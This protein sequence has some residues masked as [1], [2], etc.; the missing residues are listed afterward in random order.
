VTLI[1]PDGTES[2]LVNRPENGAFA[3]IYGF[4]GIDFLAESNAH[5]G[6]SSAGIWTLKIQ[7]AAGG[8]AGTLNSWGLEFWG[9][10]QSN[11]DL[12]VYTDDYGAFSGG[13]LAA[14]STLTDASGTDTINLA[15]VTS[16]TILNMN[17]GTAST[18]A[19][20]TLNIAGGTVIENAYLGDGNDTVTGNSANNNISGGRGNDSF[21]GSAGNDTLDGES[22]TDLLTYLESIAN[23]TFT[24]VDA[25]T[26]NIV[27]AV[28]AAWTDIT[29][30]F[31]N[32]AFTEGS[33]TRAEL[34]AYAA[35]GGGGPGAAIMGTPQNDVLNGTASN[36][37]I[38][39]DAGMDALYAGAGTDNIS[40][41]A[42]NDNYYFG[43]AG[44]AEGDVIED[45]GDSTY[46]RIYFTNLATALNPVFSLIDGNTTDLRVTTA[47]GMLTLVNQFTNNASDRVEYI[48]GQVA[49][50][51]TTGINL[52]YTSFDFVGDATGE[53]LTMPSFGISTSYKHTIHGMGG[54]DT[55][56]GSS[57]TDYLYG[58]DND[59][60]LN[61]A[62]GNDE[63]YGE[64]GS[65]VINAGDGDDR[66]YAGTGADTL[67]GENGN[68]YYYFTGAGEAAGDI[69][70][71]NGAASSTSDKIYF[72]G[73]SA[74]FVPVFGL[75]SGNST[76]LEIRTEWGTVTILNQFAADTSD[77][78]EYVYGQQGGAS[79]PMVGIN[80]AY[81]TF[82]FEGSAGNDILNMPSIGISA[83]YI[84]SI[85]GL[86]GNDTI[87]GGAG[88]DR[89]YGGDGDD[90]LSGGAQLDYLIGD[91]GADT[92]IFEA[93]TAFSGADRIEDL[94]FSE[95]DR[96]DLSDILTAYDPLSDM[97]ED[98]VQIS[99][100]GAN[101]LLRVDIDGGGDHFVH[102]ATLVGITGI[103]D[104]Q[105]LVDGGQL[106]V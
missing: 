69:I 54:N 100:S 30:N 90:V 101:S 17:G 72:T 74:A 23:F 2:V 34:E 29:K 44:E 92:F 85:N 82:Q 66:I 99:N 95:G 9:S 75:A 48:Y 68:D 102:I 52:G 50:G 28:G 98:F 1:S 49:G 89:L 7:D 31:E 45:N 18:V 35:G 53:I 71:D 5:W 19:G 80:L 76:D 77:R 20:K 79:S 83:S 70:E 38:V 55:I 86:G 26:V 47:W 103:T 13:A 81:N 88:R 58:G 6:E 24:F 67:H 36:D 43:A 51:A 104:E 12:Y 61:G 39:G 56:T 84:H 105:A 33:Y 46:D 65:D 93:L 87:T 15:T 25:V 73:L 27:H 32:F 37:T 64:A 42:G 14:R 96:I 10:A 22:G 16:N 4:S 60:I 3:G 91:A 21:V 97:I 40:G 59:D 94:D 11:D 8:N 41:G 62:G 78:I 63:L 57:R 106:I